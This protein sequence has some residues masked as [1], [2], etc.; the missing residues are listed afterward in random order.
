MKTVLVQQFPHH[1]TERSIHISGRTKEERMVNIKAEI[2]TQVESIRVKE[3]TKVTAKMSLMKLEQDRT[4]ARLKQAEAQE[5]QARIELNSEKKLRAQ[6]FSSAAAEARAI[7]NHEIAKSGL[8]LARKEHEATSVLAPFAGHVEKIHVEEGDF[9]Q[10]GQLLA[11]V[12][13]YD[14]MLVVG[15]LSELEVTYIT[16]GTKATINLVTGEELAGVVRLVATQ[17]NEQS[18]TFDVEVEIPN[19]KDSLRAGVTAEIEFHSGTIAASR[20]SPAILGL[21]EDG[22]LGVKT[23]D[24]TNNRVVFTPIKIVKAE[25][26]DMWITGL[27]ENDQVII[28]GFGFVEIGEEVIIKTDQES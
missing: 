19:K 18:R 11:A 23:V 25:T 14:P 5:K 10:P 8:T 17:A 1:L 15:A 16:E 4:S 27:A 2:S 20:I 26:N 6:G 7:T 24:R 22:E 9:V 13:D 3:S 21:N 12:M 28:R